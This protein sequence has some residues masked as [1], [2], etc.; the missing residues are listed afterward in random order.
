M[1]NDPGKILISGSSGLIGQALSKGLEKSGYAVYRLVRRPAEDNRSIFWDPAK[2]ELDSAGLEGFQT[3]INLAG[4][5]IAS[6]WTENKKKRIRDSRIKSTGLLVN[7]FQELKQK[8]VV[9]LSASGINYYGYST[10][11]PRN[12]NAPAGSGFL[13]EV[14]REWER[15]AAGAEQYGIRTVFLRFGVVLDK[16]GGALRKMLLPFKLGLGG[17]IGKGNQRMSCISLLDV[18]RIVEFLLNRDDI[19]GPVNCCA[20]C[21]VTNREFTSALARALKRPAV[22]PLPT[23]VVRLLFGQM[24]EETLLADVAAVPQKLLDAGF[25]FKH[26]DIEEIIRSALFNQD[27]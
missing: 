17:V 4:E 14:V 7:A 3:V 12:E 9:F 8:P 16:N 15:E 19:S 5:N 27:F 18:V 11:E 24:G 1:L 21:V 2:G 10:P 25:E 22:F 20:P 13:A 6:R 26:K 23:V